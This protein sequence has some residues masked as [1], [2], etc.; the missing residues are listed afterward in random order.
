M[1]KSL[2]K[3][4]DELDDDLYELYERAS[5][6]EMK[7]ADNQLAF[8]NIVATLILANAVRHLDL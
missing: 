6:R 5:K 3:T 7:H 2:E 4:V 8:D 1:K